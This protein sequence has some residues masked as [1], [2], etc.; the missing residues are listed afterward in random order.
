MKSTFIKSGLALTLAGAFGLVTFA[1]TPAPQTGDEGA[2]MGR[3][4]RR[5]GH[6]GRMGGDGFGRGFK[7]LNL[8]DEQRQQLRAIRERYQQTFA[9][10]R[11]ELRQLAETRRS[12]GTLTPEQQ[13]RAQELH[14]QL[15]ANGEKLRA[16]MLSVLTPEQQAQL[17]QQREQFKERREEFKQQRQERRA[18]RGNAPATTPPPIN[19]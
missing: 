14:A 17:K 8:S 10:Q 5:G 16:E 15:R 12:G 1:Q 13:A 11:Q 4:E 3:H 7:Q 2:P 18:R 6:E 19:N 9:P